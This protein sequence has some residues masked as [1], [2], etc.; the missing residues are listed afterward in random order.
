MIGVLQV[1]L[2]RSLT[3]RTADLSPNV[4]GS[5]SDRVAGTSST[6]GDSARRSVYTAAGTPR[7]S[8]DRQ[9]WSTPSAFAADFF[10]CEY[11]LNPIHD[12]DDQPHHPST[13][14]IPADSVRLPIFLQTAILYLGLPGNPQ[15]QY[16]Q[17][18]ES[19]RSLT[20][21]YSVPTESTTSEPWRTGGTKIHW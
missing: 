14:I 18:L 13:G 4:H 17:Y 3:N 5:Q 7:M 1:P 19:P 6:C 2:A 10:P 15:S 12:S 11:T 9:H 8:L 16:S 20:P 21:V